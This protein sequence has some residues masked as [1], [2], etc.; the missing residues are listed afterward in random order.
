MLQRP[1]YL[2]CGVSGSGKTWV[3]KQLVERYHYIP[4]DEHF[5]DLLEVITQEAT[6]PGN[7]IITECP[8]GERSFRENAEAAGL[9]VFPYFIVETPE[10]CAERY[11]KREGKPIQMSAYSRA[12]TIINR[13]IEWDAPMGTSH[14]ILGM[15]QNA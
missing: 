3:C 2:I 12:S 11:L 5:D 7:P 6:V 13:A 15:L 1:L 9:S 10:V 8:F 14:E 4:Q